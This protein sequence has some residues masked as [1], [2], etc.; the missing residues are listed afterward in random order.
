MTWSL[1]RHKK[2]LERL[3]NEDLLDDSEDDE[4]HIEETDLEEL[5]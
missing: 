1:I 5:D 2:N 4:V 3:D